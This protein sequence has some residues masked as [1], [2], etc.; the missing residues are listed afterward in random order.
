MDAKKFL[1]EHK[2]LVEQKYTLQDLVWMIAELTNEIVHEMTP[3]RP[4]NPYMRPIVR[5]ALEMLA[6]ET[7]T[8]DKYNVDLKKLMRK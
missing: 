5:K 7:G 1:E 6:A 4:S 3:D 2:V 8:K